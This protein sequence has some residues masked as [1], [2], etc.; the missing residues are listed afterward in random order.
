MAR[1][2]RLVVPGVAM[3]VRHRGVNRQNCFLED[4]DR[5]VYL[6]CLKELATTAGCAIHAYCL[7]TNH[8]HLLLTPS[9][10]KGCA[11]LMR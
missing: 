11:T 7:M 5:L 3:H 4:I 8:V 10:L 6:S 9:D 1:P 2:E